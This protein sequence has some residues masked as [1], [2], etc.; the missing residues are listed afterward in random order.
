MLQL[1]GISKQLYF[2]DVQLN[3]LPKLPFEHLNHLS[4]FS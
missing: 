1:A 3:L 4:V 2:H